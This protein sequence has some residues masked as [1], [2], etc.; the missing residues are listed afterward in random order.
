MGILKIL[1]DALPEIVH[2]PCGEV[3]P[4]TLNELSKGFI[5]C[6]NCKASLKIPDH[7]RC[8][9]CGAPADC[10]IPDFRMESGNAKPICYDCAEEH[11]LYKYVY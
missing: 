2:C 9:E 6:N 4:F 5:L 11:D 10:A 3:V 7:I 1:R 8:E